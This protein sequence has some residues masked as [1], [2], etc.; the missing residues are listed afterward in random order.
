MK[1]PELLYSS[2]TLF[3]NFLILSLPRTLLRNWSFVLL[4]ADLIVHEDASPVYFH[5]HWLLS[6]CLLLALMQLMA[7]LG[8]PVFIYNALRAKSYEIVQSRVTNIYL[9]LLRKVKSGIGNAWEQTVR[10]V[11]NHHQG[12][13]LSMLNWPLH[14]PLKRKILGNCKL[15]VI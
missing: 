12:L 15:M 7:T 6:H 2:C 8:Y 10:T 14:C 9:K 3:V 5:W 4:E 1:N 11:P 13:D